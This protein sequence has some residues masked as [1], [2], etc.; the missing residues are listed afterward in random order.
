M[1]H[2]LTLLTM[3]PLLLFA[4]KETELPAEVFFRNGPAEKGTIQYKAWVYNPASIVFT[5]A[6]AT[7]K[8]LE[9]RDVREIHIEDKDIYV[10]AEVTRYTNT[11]TTQQVEYFENETPVKAW[12]FLRLLSKGSRLSLYAYKDDLKTHYFFTDSTGNFTTLRYVRVLKSGDMGTSMVEK[13]YYQ[14]QLG[15]YIPA[16]DSKARK[17]LGELGWR[18]ADMIAMVRRINADEQA[19]YAGA[20]L[21]DNVRRQALFVGAGASYASYS[22]ESTVPYLSEM[23]FSSS[24]NPIFYVGY[25]LSGMRRLQRFHMQIVAGYFGYETTGIYDRVD[26]QGNDVREQLVINSQNLGINFDVLYAPVQTK[27]LTWELGPSF[28]FVYPFSLKTDR[29]TTAVNINGDPIFVPPVNL[30]N[31]PRLIFNFIT[32]LT[33]R[34]KH[35]IRFLYS[36]FQKTDDFG[37]SLPKDRIISLGYHYSFHL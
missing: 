32:Q 1:K 14:D 7:P 31:R 16:G 12:L 10:G 13:R 24:V 20:E 11:I 18:D 8:T 29:T 4:Q 26:N 33:I 22:F 9:P 27:T 17:M 37:G 2:L 35:S 28:Q 19:G 30:N 6:N 3:L 23:D 34:E 21:D 25:R 15:A 36:P 5:G